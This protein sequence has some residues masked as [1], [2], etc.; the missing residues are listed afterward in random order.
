MLIGSDQG[1]SKT[2]IEC[3]YDTAELDMLISDNFGLSTVKNDTRFSI[4]KRSMKDFRT[5]VKIIVNCIGLLSSEK[6]V[7]V[8][9][10][11]L[12]ERPG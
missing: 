1:S 11:T 5:K 3:L 8:S 10:G 7:S 4:W 12:L 2:G 6:K 9:M